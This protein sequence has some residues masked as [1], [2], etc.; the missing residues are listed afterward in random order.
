[1][2]TKKEPVGVVAAITPWNSPLY[3]TFLKLAPALAAGNTIVIK[4]SE[5]TSASLLEF[6]KLTEEAGVP[7]GVIN[8][9]T[10]FG[11]EVGD[12]LTTHPHISKVAFTG[13]PEAARHIVKNTA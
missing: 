13:G 10:G 3:L 2:Y 4:P 7:D 9:I 1:V 11:N 5:Y 8:I 6:A 12:A